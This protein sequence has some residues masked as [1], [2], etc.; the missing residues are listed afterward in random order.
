MNINSKH[1]FVLYAFTDYLIL[2]E[3]FICALLNRKKELFVTIWF[4]LFFPGTFS[5]D[6]VPY[7]CRQTLRAVKDPL[8]G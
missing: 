6:A 3:I 7:C 4:L 1:V 2:P 8:S 5:G